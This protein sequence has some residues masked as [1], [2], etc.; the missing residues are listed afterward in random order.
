MRGSGTTGWRSAP[1]CA[2]TGWCRTG[3]S[4]AGRKVTRAVYRVTPAACKVTGSPRKVTHSRAKVTVSGGKVTP[5]TQGDGFWLWTV[6]RVSTCH[7]AAS[8]GK[9]ALGSPP[10]APPACG[11]G[12][13]APR[14]RGSAGPP[15]R[16]REGR[17]TWSCGAGPS[18]SGVGSQTQP[19]PHHPGPK[20][21]AFTR[22]SAKGPP[23]P[24]SGE[25]EESRR[26]P[27]IPRT[28]QRSVR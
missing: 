2:G 27:A 5:E 9:A 6:S 24:C 4:C 12:E 22:Q 28:S 8:C 20:P 21:L 16:R 1:R 19:P 7:L 3:G 11:R 25:F 17:E 10:P 13:P 14:S 23:S 18:R 26:G 15:S